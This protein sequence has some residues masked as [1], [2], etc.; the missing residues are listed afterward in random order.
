[1]KR[2]LT[3]DIWLILCLIAITIVLWINNKN[4]KELTLTISRQS[5]AIDYCTKAGK[6]F[7]EELD[8]ELEVGKEDGSLR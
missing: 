5:I 1:M 7:Y 4:I 2:N 3:S 8:A 6:E